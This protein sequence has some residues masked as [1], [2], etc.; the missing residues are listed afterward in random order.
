MPLLYLSEELAD[1][2]TVKELLGHAKIETVL[3]YA[4]S[5]P[6]KMREAT[7]RAANAQERLPSPALPSRRRVAMR[8]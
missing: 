6:E 3:I 7:Q 5:T 4:H 8:R 2:N 1:L